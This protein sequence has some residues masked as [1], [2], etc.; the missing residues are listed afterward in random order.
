MRQWENALADSSKC[1]ELNPKFWKGHGRKIKALVQ[2][3][4]YIAA[5]AAVEVALKAVPNMPEILSLRD[6]IAPHVT[7]ARRK[8]KARS[9]I[10]YQKPKRAAN[11]ERD[12]TGRRRCARCER[13]AAARPRHPP[14]C[15]RSDRVL[16]ILRI[17]FPTLRIGRPACRARCA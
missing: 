14:S 8:S 2:M 13:R 4:D 5:Q 16:I 6:E 12:G 17:F 1:I 15:C 7:R 10:A 9:V 3:G 11:R